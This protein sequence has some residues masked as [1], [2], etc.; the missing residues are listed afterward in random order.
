MLTE[1]Q[2]Q[3]AARLVRIAPYLPQEMQAELAELIRD[4]QA[5]EGASIIPQ[6][7]IEDAVKAVPNA[8]EIVRDLRSIG[9]PGWMT[10]PP[11][12]SKEQLNKSDPAIDNTP[13]YLK[14]KK[15]RGWRKPTEMESP[16]GIKYVDQLCDVQDRIDKV[17]RIK[18]FGFAGLKDD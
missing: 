8:Q 5:S 15:P 4:L 1:N 11:G 14:K 16:P 12:P 6:S 17:E 10:P 3:R 18:S 13:D 9:E 2:I 7:A